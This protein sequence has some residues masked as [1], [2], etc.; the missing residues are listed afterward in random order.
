MSKHWILPGKPIFPR[1]PTEEIQYFLTELEEATTQQELVDV[2]I[3]YVQP[4]GAT[5][6]LVGTMPQL[7][8]T[9]RQQLGH[10]LLNA[11]PND[12]SARYFSMDYL[13]K[14]PTIKLVR[15][16][17]ENFTWSD[18]EVTRLKSGIS[19][20]G[21]AG[22]FGLSSGYTMTI[23]SFGY[24][25]VGFSIAGE[26]L[27]LSPERKRS[28]GVIARFA[29]YRGLQF[30]RMLQN[31]AELKLTA[32]EREVLQLAAEGWKEWQIADRL[33]ITSHAIDKYMRSCR[34]KLSSRNTNHA[35][36]TALRKGVIS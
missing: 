30:R 16:G 21:E 8:A 20:M 32:R 17:L 14:D 31:G 7:G 10:V 18:G 4:F 34:D 15:E 1:R 23:P 9:K 6:V 29:V 25:N 36:A 11:W 13:F 24:E 19:I 12:W 2:L 5:N 22:E 35:I 27:E 26:R 3:R 33:G 28:L